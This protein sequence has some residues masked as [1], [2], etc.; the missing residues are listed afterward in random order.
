MGFFTGFA[1]GIFDDLSIFFQI[2]EIFNGLKE[3]GKLIPT[4]LFDTGLFFEMFKNSLY[5]IINKAFNFNPFN[6]GG[7]HTVQQWFDNITDLMEDFFDNWALNDQ[8]NIDFIS[9][10]ENKFNLAF[11]AAHL[12]GYIIQQMMVGGFL[13][14]GAAADAAGIAGKLGSITS[15]LK[16]GISA[17]GKMIKRGASKAKLVAKGFL[18]KV[19]DKVCKYIDDLGMKLSK[20]APG[21]FA[22]LVVGGGGRIVDDIAKYGKEIIENIA[23]RAAKRIEAGLDAFHPSRQKHV[24]DRHSLNVPGKKGST[25]PKGWSDPKILDSVEDVAD[26]GKYVGSGTKGSKLYRKTIDGVEITVAKGDIGIIGVKKVK[27]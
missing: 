6:D 14:L 4:L 9:T 3:I 15:K 7:D 18:N 24:L 25:F 2:G 8:S 5:G 12:V 22:V 21:S 11:T 16:D 19:A 10:D 20:S 26:T 23:E 1:T 17:V 27:Y 13:L